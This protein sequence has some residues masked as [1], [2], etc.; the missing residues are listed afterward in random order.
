MALIVSFL[1][2]PYRVYYNSIIFCMQTKIG[3]DILRID[4]FVTSHKRG[5]EAFRERIFTL[6]ELRQN[7]PEQLATILCIK[8]AVMKALE[9]PYDFWLTMSTN[10]KK[11]G[12]VTCTLTDRN[13]ARSIASFD[14]SVSHEGEWVIAVAVVVYV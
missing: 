4:R 2:V 8:E 7:T 13:I 12:K 10:R 6:Q 5:G 11:N 1:A 14:T 3:I 9:L